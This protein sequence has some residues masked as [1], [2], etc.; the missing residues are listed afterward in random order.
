[1]KGIASFVA[2]GSVSLALGACV[3]VTDA[4]PEDPSGTTA[5]SPS[6]NGQPA[7]MGN[8]KSSAYWIWHSGNGH[9]HLRTTS[10]GTTHRYSGR[11]S[12]HGAAKIVRAH[13]V[14]KEKDDRVKF[15]TDRVSFD[16]NTG[17]SGDG[18]DFD[19]AGS[20]VDFVLEI[21]GTKQP[22]HVVVGAAEHRPSAGN[23]KACP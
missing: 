6:A 2:I 3:V 18:F 9:W 5:A 19:V 13:S 20:C 14:S 8:A 1:M 10:G 12:G 15:L 16:M 22:E 11:V 7:N 17:T 4:P 21:D 23:F